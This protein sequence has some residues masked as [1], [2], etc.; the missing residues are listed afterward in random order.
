L[1]QH[2]SK[3]VRDI[4]SVA[5]SMMHC[6]AVN[7]AL[8]TCSLVWSLYSDPCCYLAFGWEFLDS[9]LP[10]LFSFIQNHSEHYL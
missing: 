6:Y 9:F 2:N 3:G 4:M 8:V 5:S 10:I 1:L 7:H